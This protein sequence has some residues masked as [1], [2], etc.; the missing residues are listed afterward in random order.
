LESVRGLRNKRKCVLQQVRTCEKN[1]LP[2]MEKDK[3]KHA[4]REGQKWKK[5]MSFTGPYMR[6]ACSAEVTKIKG[7]CVLSRA[8]DLRKV[9]S[10]KVTEIYEKCVLGR[11]I[12]VR[13]GK[14]CSAGVTEI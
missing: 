5:S 8:I 1:V 9:C 11:A 3:I 14:V 7:K 12:D 10:A 4:L 2:S 6:K 13:V